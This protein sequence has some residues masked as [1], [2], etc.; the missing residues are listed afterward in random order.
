MNEV[1]YEKNDLERFVDHLPV[2]IVITDENMI[3]Q[4]NNMFS[5]DYI[6]INK[7]QNEYRGPGDFIGCENSF[8]SPKGCGHSIYCNSCK[9]RK[10]VKNSIKTMIPSE[11]CEI[12][13]NILKDGIRKKS[14]FKIK[15]IPIANNKEKQSLI[16]ITNI[17]E[18]KEMQ[19]EIISIN[20]FYHTL[21]KFF[22]D[23]LWEMDADKNYVYFN[24]N[25]EESTGQPI[26]KLIKENL[27]IGMHPDDVEKYNNEIIKAYENKEILKVE[28][29]LKTLSGE[30]RN[31]LSS[32]N[33]IYGISGEFSGYVG[34]AIDIT[35]EKK[36]KEELFRL[37]EEA[38][39][40][41]RAKSEFLANMSHEIR[42]PLNGIIGMTD[43]TL[44]TNLT[45]DQRENLSIVKNCAYNLLALIN[46]ILDLSK[47]E[48]NK[49]TIEN[50]GF[51]LRKL[52]KNVMYTNKAKASEKYIELFYKVDDEIPE[53][54]TGDEYKLGQILNNLVS[55]AVKFTEEGFV[56]IEVKKIGRVNKFL[57]IEFSVEDLGI[58][59]SEEDMKFLFKSFSQ[60]DG[61]ITR[62]YGG[63]GLGLSISQKLVNLMGGEIK[64][65]SQKG[66]GSRFYFTIRLAEAQKD[67]ENFK[68][69]I[70]NSK[71]KKEENILLVEDNKVNKL[72][73][74]KML[75]EIGYEK[76]RVASNGIEALNLMEKNK[77]DVILMDIQMPELDG[78]ETVKIIRKNEEKLGSHTWIIA[79]TSH[80]LKGDKEKFLAQGM[81]D[82]ISKPIDI[83]KLSKGLEEIH[84]KLNDD[85]QNIIKEYLIHRENKVNDF[86]TIGEDT[87]KLLLNKSVIL[88]SYLDNKSGQASNYCE[89]EKIAHDIKME[90]EEKNFNN[91]K[92]LAFK[93]ELAARK[94]DDIGI[95]NNIEK[96][97][98]ILKK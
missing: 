21:I 7:A 51:N 76:V 5:S 49:V 22:P 25:W 56:M 71:D 39:A 96:I 53:I 40:A 72:V 67:L 46:N 90:S 17:T 23:M 32:G 57:E 15:A 31:I 3:V 29:R 6:N 88:N 54:L 94:Q 13:H 4:Y 77:F 27:I 61:S 68:G 74:K 64:V 8:I 34:M 78:L 43:L 52:I 82:Y 60:V 30:Y 69:N 36:T 1:K 58:G 24:K 10:I 98:S 62:K 18:Y 83:N 37:K 44:A 92:T 33:P 9:L 91:M 66:V 59:L 14:W 26:E 97:V 11:Y 41:N 50:I 86:Y 55:N 80:A 81:D 20:N 75:S 38:E 47:I 16:V 12:Q 89:I 48:A 42:T 2:L 87:K 45:N 28:Y 84:N 65:Q 79:T 85:E 35:K 73:I 63:T 19:N 95:R 70:L 93:I